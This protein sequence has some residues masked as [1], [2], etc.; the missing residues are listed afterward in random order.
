MENENNYWVEVWDAVYNFDTETTKMAWVN[1]D[2]PRAEE[3]AKF[4]AELVK[5]LALYP[6]VRITRKG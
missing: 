3:E 2:R 6:K 5:D 1:F 4:V